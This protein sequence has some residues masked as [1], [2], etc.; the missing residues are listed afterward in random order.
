M[1]RIKNE[2]MDGAK[3]MDLKTAALNT[4]YAELKDRFEK[5]PPREQDLELITR[6]QEEL[7]IKEKYCKEAEENMEKFKNMLIN[8]EENYNKY[9]NSNPKTG[10]VLGNLK[11]EKDANKTISK[12]NT[13]IS[14]NN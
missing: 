1:K 7:Q 5:R 2:F 3:I 6:L 10:S 9:F 8:N 13:L 12:K 11:K 14:K 4:R